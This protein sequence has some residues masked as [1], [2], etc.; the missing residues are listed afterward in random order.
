MK[1]SSNAFKT[2]GTSCNVGNA[3]GAKPS[4]RLLPFGAASNSGD[5]VKNTLFG[6]WGEESPADPRP[7]SSRPRS[8][9][10]TASAAPSGPPPQASARGTG[11][12]APEAATAPLGSPRDPLGNSGVWAS[13]AQL[14]AGATGDGGLALGSTL[15][16]LRSDPL[17]HAHDP[18]VLDAP[19][20]DHVAPHIALGFEPA[21]GRGLE[22]TPILLP[23]PAPG[24]RR[25]G[26]PWTATGA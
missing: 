5:A 12:G 3:M 2:D 17:P 9:A 26:G 4:I 15:V 24:P 19:L 25:A 21:G 20:V 22:M 1:A 18:G 10:S 11:R 14:R 8:A 6:G 13:G 7:P 16:G 23:A